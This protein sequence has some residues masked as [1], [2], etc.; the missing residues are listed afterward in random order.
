MSSIEAG[1][2]NCIAQPTE[3]PAESFGRDANDGVHDAVEPLR[4]SNDGRI[5]LEAALPKL[6]ADHGDRMRAVADVFARLEATAKHGMDAYDIKIIRGDDTAGKARSPMLSVV[7]VILETKNA[8]K[9]RGVF[10][11]VEK[12]GPRK[13]SSGHSPRCVPPSAMS[14]SLTNDR[15]IRWDSTPSIQ[16]KMLRWCL[17]REGSSKGPRGWKP[18]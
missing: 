6:V 17:F 13:W 8:S 18:R 5:A 14:R 11:Q 3:R 10:L 9:E 15:G 16:L 12:V 7:P 1:T 4:L 2:Q